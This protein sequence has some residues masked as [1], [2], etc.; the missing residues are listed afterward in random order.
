ME[1]VVIERRVRRSARAEEQGGSAEAEEAEAAGWLEVV[2]TLA[3]VV[4]RRGPS[5]LLRVL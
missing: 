5:P 3:V 2:E 1:S 4:S